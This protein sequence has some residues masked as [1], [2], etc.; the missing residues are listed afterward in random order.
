[1]NY[2]KI[3]IGL[4][5]FSILPAAQAGVTTW[6][7][8]V[9]LGYATANISTSDYQVPVADV[10][11]HG[12]GSKIN[13]GYRF[14]QNW[15]IEA[16]YIYFGKTKSSQGDFSTRAAT[17]SLIGI[18]PLNEQVAVN[19]KAGFYRSF[20][21]VDD[22]LFPNSKKPENVTGFSYGARIK[23]KLSEAVD[24]SLDWDQIISRKDTTLQTNNRLASVN[25]TY[26]FI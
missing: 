12:L 22:G 16:D 1:M 2:F 18:V 23:Y 6:Y 8:G 24:A 15:A 14:H 4:I 9:G 10:N 20:V 19:G 3:L 13:L 11:S 21:S 17:L 7:A 5:G 26:N 25:I